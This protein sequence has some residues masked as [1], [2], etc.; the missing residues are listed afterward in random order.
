MAGR[1]V[2]R[3][4]E[5]YGKD[6]TDFF[7]SGQTAEDLAVLLETARIFDVTVQTLLSPTL[8]HQDVTHAVIPVDVS[9]AY[10]NGHLYVP[11][12]ALES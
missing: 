1:D 4:P 12:R 2:L 7:R 10:V 5:D 3:V 9:R 11:F 8:P 6:W